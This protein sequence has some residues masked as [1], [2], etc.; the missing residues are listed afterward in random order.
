MQPKSFIYLLLILTS[1]ISSGDWIIEEVNLPHGEVVYLKS[2]TY[3]FRGEHN[4]TIISM[5]GDK[6]YREREDID[7]GQFAPIRY[8]IENGK[9]ILIET[10]NYEHLKNSFDNIEKVEISIVSTQEYLN[11]SI[12]YTKVFNSN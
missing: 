1:C 10:S 8:K 5:H 11:K 7:I 4:R 9:F 2:W 3:G 12:G 6:E